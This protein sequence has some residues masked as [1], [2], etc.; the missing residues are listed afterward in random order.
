M[1]TERLSSTTCAPV[2]RV[3]NGVECGFEQKK[4]L[5]GVSTA[6]CSRRAEVVVMSGKPNRIGV[7]RVSDGDER[8]GA[9]Q[10]LAGRGGGGM[11]DS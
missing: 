3:L 8:R 11:F 6:G 7:A 1:A 10:N 4:A 9:K 5:G 2:M